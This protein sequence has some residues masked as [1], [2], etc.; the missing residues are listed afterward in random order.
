MPNPWD[1]FANVCGA[2]RNGGYLCCY[3]PNTNQLEA[4]VK[5]MWEEGLSEV[6]SFETLQREI[7][8]HQGG[9]RPSSE[10]IGHTGYLTFGRK[11]RR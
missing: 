2:I 3:V 9:V 1:A 4:A 8:V 5:A 6:R 11:V 7:V 10:M